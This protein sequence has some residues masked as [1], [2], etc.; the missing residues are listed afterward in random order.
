[1]RELRAMVPEYKQSSFATVLKAT[2]D[3]NPNAKFQVTDYLPDAAGQRVQTTDP[4]GVVQRTLYDSRG[5][6]VEQIEAFGSTVEAHTK[7][8]RDVPGNI[9]EVQSPRY[10]DA[11]DANGFQKAND[12]WTYTRRDLQKTHIVAVGDADYP[13]GA[14]VTE[15]WTYNVDGT[16]NTHTDF[17]S[18]AWQ[19]LWAACCAN[20]VTAQIDPLATSQTN[21]YD[22]FGQVT[23]QQTLHDTTVFRQT[24]TRYDSR[25]R[26]VAQT[27]WLIPQSNV[28]PNNP[29]I[30]GGD[31]P[32]DP[33]AHN[34][35]GKTIGLT[36]RF[37][38][39][40]D[41]T[42]R[43]GL[44]G[45]GTQVTKLTGN[46]TYNVSIAQLLANVNA[47]LAAG[48]QN[49]FGANPDGSKVPGSAIAT[50]NPMDEISISVRD[51][52]GRRIAD[53]ILKQD[54]TP[55]A[56][57]LMQ[58]D[59]LVA[60]SGLGSL[61]ES[62]QVDALNH[63]NRT[64]SDAAGRIIQ[65]LDALGKITA[66][67]YD[68]AGNVLSVRDPS[69][70][71]W[72]AT[73]DE[74]GR[75]ITHADTQE[76][77]EGTKQLTSYD[78]Q[79]NVTS[80][81][82]AKGQAATAQFDVRNRKVQAID[83]LGGVT[84]W[85]YDPAGNL[86]ELCDADNQQAN[87]PTVWT[88]DVRNQKLTETYPDHAP[89]SEI[90]NQGYDRKLFTYDLAKQPATFT[91]Q[92]GDTVTHTFDLAGRLL[93]RD[94]R[95]QAN[96]PSGLIAD[97]DIFTFD[98]ANRT[99]TSRSGRY[100]NAVSYAYADGAG[101]VTSESIAV[102]FS[103]PVTYVVGN[104]YDAVVNRVQITYPDGSIVIRAYTERDQL[105]RIDY[106]GTMIASFAYDNAG[107]RLTRILG[108][109][110]STKTT[111]S[112]SRKDNLTTSIATSGVTSF[113]YA[114]DANKNKLSE[115]IG[116]PM[117]AYG[118]DNTSY[119]AEDRLSAWNR[120]DGQHSQA[121]NLSSAGDWN[122]F[123]ENGSQQPRTHSPVHGLTNVGITPLLHDRKGNLLRTTQRLQ[124]KV[125]HGILITALSLQLQ[126]AQRAPSRMT[127][128]DAD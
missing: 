15:S 88:Y 50:I 85:K 57:R 92:Q 96:S 30:A 66:Y 83:R 1:M 6:V 7:T 28:D 55:V 49:V 31:Q 89:G 32:G 122:Q 110:K 79:G 118:Y 77:A 27:A 113:A 11:N 116:A 82:D 102:N 108:D 76:Q 40:D 56:G 33:P 63:T 5:R 98:D 90:G 71:G 46:G 65:S 80:T 47:T 10:F 29:P 26:I 68:V 54:G 115:T 101:R 127:R 69:N 44:D 99:L 75:H 120:H 67:K 36:T 107:R 121:W 25:G 59:V 100:N 124:L 70:I 20:R 104:R 22:R 24:T 86:L 128:A 62:T 87:K 64:R 84:T 125:M 43:Q 103:Q 60:V 51:S 73:Y 12:T 123:T 21:E 93:Q 53:G 16:A 91:D 19:T 95:S 119:D 94:Y 48:G 13:Q 18:N 9:V 97:S 4:R 3:L 14:R 81:T 106:N 41:L 126:P 52:A 111:W 61:L 8:I 23:H 114:Y 117:A 35:D 34:V 74:R 17:R 37:L 72:D 105:S 39:D 42:D 78:A 38:Y 109:S 45:A 58:L 2:R 112:Y